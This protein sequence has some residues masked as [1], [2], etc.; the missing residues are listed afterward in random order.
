[1]TFPLFEDQHNPYQPPQLLLAPERDD[2]PSGNYR[3]VKIFVMLQMLVIFVGLGVSFSNIYSI[4][5][6]GPVLSFLGLVTAILCWRRGSSW[7]LVL[8]GSGPLFSIFV[9]LLINVQE[10]GPGDAE[11]PVPMYGLGY[12]GIAGLI[13]AITLIEIRSRENP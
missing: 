11:R 3:W 5:V 10:W 12:L 9:F 1:M 4:L 7:G 13:A 6:T 8:G 2:V